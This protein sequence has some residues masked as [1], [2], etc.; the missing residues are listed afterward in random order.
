VRA[1]NECYNVHF[2][3]EAEMTV[4]R[5]RQEMKERSLWPSNSMLAI[6]GA[7]PIAVLIGSKRSEE[8]MVLRVGVRPDVWRQGHGKHILTSL[9]Q[10]L[11]VLGPPRLVA[12]VPLDLPSAAALFRSAGYRREALYRDFERPA[13]PKRTV[14]EDWVSAIGFEDL[15]AAGAFEDRS[16][17]AWDRGL[18]TLSLSRDSLRGLAI[19]S[20]T[21][22]EA[23]LLYSVREGAAPY[24]EVQTLGCAD[25]RNRRRLSHLLIEA[26]AERVPMSI[27]ISKLAAGEPPDGDLA[28][29]G[30]VETRAWERLAAVAAPG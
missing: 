14:P 9:S 8:V 17:I 25:R 3:A 27:R 18:A 7:D 6:A 11:A 21:R 10:K 16:G 26:L 13:G 5:F 1:V 12:E 2:P 24:A 29:L 22:I 30:F 23:Y 4:P 20:P 28:A 19:V 15:E